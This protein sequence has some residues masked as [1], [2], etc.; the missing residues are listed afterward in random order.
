MSTQGKVLRISHIEESDRECVTKTTEKK[1]SY[2]PR[3]EEVSR[4]RNQ[5]EDT[6][7]FPPKAEESPSTKQSPG[8]TPSAELHMEEIDQLVRMEP[9]AGFLTTNTTEL[10]QS[11]CIPG[12]EKCSENSF[13]WMY[14]E[15]QMHTIKEFLSCSQKLRSSDAKP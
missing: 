4:G 6:N 2:N 11:H 9:S 13:L 14:Q 3:V 10:D 15:F 7:V 5:S 8:D 1:Q 12:Q